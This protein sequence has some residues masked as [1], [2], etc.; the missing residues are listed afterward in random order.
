MIPPES[1][2]TGNK[3][4]SYL[5][6]LLDSNLLSSCYFWEKKQGC[7]ASFFLTDIFSRGNLILL[8]GQNVSVENFIPLQRLQRAASSLMSGDIFLHLSLSLYFLPTSLSLL[9]LLWKQ[10]ALPV[11]CT[12][13]FSLSQECLWACFQ[14][15]ALSD[16]QTYG[17]GAELL[18]QMSG[19]Q[20]HLITLGKACL[21]CETAL[22][23]AHC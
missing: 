10:K 8:K 18:S 16:A 6:L 11:P 17:R 22:V 14:S 13:S 23:S 12:N 3:G 21:D 4:V 20:W 9:F 2:R 7:L 15:W 19:Q 5:Q 1:F